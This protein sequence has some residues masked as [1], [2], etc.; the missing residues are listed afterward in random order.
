MDIYHSQGSIEV[1]CGCMFSGKSEE[2]IRRL[3]RCQFANQKIKIFNHSIDI[4]YG[5]NEIKSHDKNGMPC[6]MI[7]DINQV[8]EIIE[9]DDEVIAIDEIQFFTGDV[10]KVLNQI[11][12]MKKRVIVAGLDQDFKGEPFNDMPNI[13]ATADFVTKIHA[14]C[15]Q[16]GSLATKTQRLIDGKPASKKDPLIVVDAAEKYEARCRHCHKIG[17]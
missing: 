3:K 7:N 17:E 10:T 12:D 11:A 13:L 14:I 4:R 9:K 1:I 15:V 5:T 6:F 16:C 2:L 8:L